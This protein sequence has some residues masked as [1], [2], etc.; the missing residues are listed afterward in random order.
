MSRRGDV[1]AGGAYGLVLSGLAIL[2]FFQAPQGELSL[3]PPLLGAALFGWIPLAYGLALGAGARWTARRFAARPRNVGLGWLAAYGL[4]LALALVALLPLLGSFAPFPTAAT[5]LY[6]EL[7]WSYAG[8]HTVHFA[9]VLAFIV[10]YCGLS[11]V[12]FWSGA[13][14][15]LAKLAAVTL[16]LF[17]AGF[18]GHAPAVAGGMGMLQMGSLAPGLIRAAGLSLLLIVL[19]LLPDG[20]SLQ[21]WTRPAA[22]LWSGWLLIW[23]VLPWASAPAGALV[24][25]PA[26]ELAIMAVGLG[27]GLAALAQRLRRGDAQ[28][29]RQLRPVLMGFATAFLLAALL[30]LALLRAPE[31]S[32]RGLQTPNAYLAFGP[33]LLPWLLLPLSLVIAIRRGLWLSSGP[34]PALQGQIPASGRD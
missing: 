1:L 15:G 10:A 30:W 13:H 34:N 5:Q 4:A 26:L 27:S 19:Y 31:W 14:H 2:P 8:A 9:L 17:A 16:L 6:L 22:F 20:R 29:R 12:V 25:Q 18:F 33:Y 32:L 24:R 28:I 3:A 11:S 7:G 23:L 21:R